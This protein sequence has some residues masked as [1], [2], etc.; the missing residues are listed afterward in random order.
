MTETAKITKI[1]GNL[2]T[3]F[4]GNGAGSAAAGSADSC[5]T[6]GGASC[7]MKSR[8]YT[9]RNSRGLDLKPGDEVEISVAPSRAVVAAI[10]VLGIPVASFALCWT[11]AMRLFVG[12]LV[13][14]LAGFC[15]LVIGILPALVWKRFRR[16]DDMPE[17]SAVVESSDPAAPVSQV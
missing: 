11:V 2:V 5:A 15:G 14:A 3:V 9:A 1:E 17:V 12:E 6:C 7:L 4:C 13:P 8:P 10:V 16:F